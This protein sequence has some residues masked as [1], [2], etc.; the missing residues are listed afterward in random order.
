MEATCNAQF[1]VIKFE[2][3]LNKSLQHIFFISLICCRKLGDLRED[4]PVAISLLLE[5]IAFTS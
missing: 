5:A 4:L 2:A 1:T 3:G